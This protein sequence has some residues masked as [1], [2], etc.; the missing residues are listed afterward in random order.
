[1]T[2]DATGPAPRV[3]D[4]LLESVRRQ[5]GID[6]A[7]LTEYDLDGAEVRALAGNGEHLALSVGARVPVA[8]SVC[9]ASILGYAPGTVADTRQHQITRR[10]AWDRRVPIGAFAAAPVQLSSG[11]LFGGLCVAHHAPLPELGP[12]TQPFL[13]AMADVLGTQLDHEYHTQRQSSTELDAVRSLFA[14]GRLSIVLQPIVELTTGDTIGVEALSRFATDPP[15]PPNLWFSTAA[16]HGRGVDLESAAIA[17][18]LR[19]LPR[20][21][22]SWYMAL[23]ASPDLVQSGELDRLIPDGADHR[24]VVEITEH[25]AVADYDR[26]MSTLAGVRGRG[27]RIAVDDAGAGFASLR[28]VVQLQPDIIKIDGSLIRGLDAEPLHRAMVE[29]LV[30]FAANT[31]ATLVA[32]AVETASELAVLQDLGVTVAQGH[33][34]ASPGGVEDLRPQYPVAVP[35]TFRGGR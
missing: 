29:S 2:E 31:G 1:M 4:Q 18:A 21:P 23:N 24:L 33:L 13:A 32:E 27:G 11:A 12:V 15:R 7:Y 14:D 3:I 20:L 6:V 22:S 26:L 19:L 10:L 30:S 17:R 8:E 5:L 35:S 25:A 28:H 9:L 34:F 16:R